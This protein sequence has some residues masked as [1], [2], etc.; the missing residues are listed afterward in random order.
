MKFIKQAILWIVLVMPFMATGQII[1]SGGVLNINNASRNSYYGL[2]VNEWLG[3][4]WTCKD[5]NNFF[6][7]DLAPLNPRI[8]G[9]GDKIV[10]YNSVTKKYNNIE[11]GTVYNLSDARAKENVQTISSGLNTLLQ[12]RPVSFNWKNEANEVQMLSTLDDEIY[13]DTI[14]I[15]NAPSD[16]QLQYGFL[17]QEVAE[18]IPEAVKTDE[19]GN[20]LVNYNAIIPILVQAVQE[21]QS[22]VQSQSLI[23]EQLTNGQFSQLRNVSNS[24]ILSCTP[25]P[26]SNNVTVTYQ[27]EDNVNSA[28]IMITNLSGVI[29]KMIEI[30][31][32]DTSVNIDIS[33]LTSGLHNITLQ[34]DNSI[35]YSIRLTKE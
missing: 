4:Y 15:A 29:E 34:V 7:L 24:K 23:I 8:A 27:L 33:S 30:S 26:S 2:Y 13:S 1:Y 32:N 17:A 28:N 14:T 11:V 5:N 31:K 10:F 35:V 21:L 19:G 6:Q 12:L 25:N 3:M 22:T 16:D 9:S 20:M 18:V